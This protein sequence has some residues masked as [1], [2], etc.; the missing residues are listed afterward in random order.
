MSEKIFEEVSNGNFTNFNKL[1]EAQQIDSMK[2]WNQ[3]MW[4][5][6]C[7]QNTV[8]ENDVFDPIIK[9]IESDV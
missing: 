5:K 6:Y 9:L 7:M 4:I 8:S 1:N 3:E 2:T